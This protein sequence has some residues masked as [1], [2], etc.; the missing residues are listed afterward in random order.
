M[1]KIKGHLEYLFLK[2]LVQGL[3]EESLS[4]EEARAFAQEFL[5]IEPFT[6]LQDA[7]TKMESFTSRNSLFNEL[8]IYL[9]AY[10]KE[11]HIDERVEKMRFYIKNN[12]LDEALKVA[13]G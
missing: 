11:K 4:V 8:I 13:K 1:E 3:E 10:E 9:G 7:E 12:N 5:S 2:A 6:S